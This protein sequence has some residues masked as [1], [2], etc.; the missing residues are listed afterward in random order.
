MI[1]FCLLL[2][3]R[4][5]STPGLHFSV[6]PGRWLTLFNFHLRFS[7]C[8]VHF[9]FYF[10]DHASTVQLAFN[11]FIC[12]QESLQLVWQFVVLGSNQI[13]MFVERFDFI[14]HAI[15][16]VNQAVVLFSARYK[17]MLQ[18]FSLA[19]SGLQSHLR[20]SFLQSQ[21]FASADFILVSFLQLTLSL[22][23]FSVLVFKETDF[24][25]FLFQLV[26]HLG[27]LIDGCVYPRLNSS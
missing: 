26:F 5:T 16:I 12:L 9:V 8:W 14:L 27:L 25:I 17:F 23:M 2:H 15:R 4:Q 13:H 24:I 19:H 18:S 3:W 7:D 22:L 20:I 11:D 1:G 21:F 6:S 10:I